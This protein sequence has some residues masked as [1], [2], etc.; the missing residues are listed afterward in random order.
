MA[1][2]R[3]RVEIQCARRCRSFIGL[4]GEGPKK[5]SS[6]RAEYAENIFKDT[7]RSISQ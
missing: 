3:L 6:V 1:P 2:A 4:P 5:I 7:H